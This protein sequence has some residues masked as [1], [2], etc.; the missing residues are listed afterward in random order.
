MFSDQGLYI[1]EHSA[2]DVTFLITGNSGYIPSEAAYAY[3]SYEAD[4]GN[5]SAGT[6]EQLAEEYVRM[7]SDLKG[8]VSN[9][10][11]R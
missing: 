6:A 5:F 9:G 1:K 2:Y 3:R 4:T 10:T 7:L 11:D 8:A